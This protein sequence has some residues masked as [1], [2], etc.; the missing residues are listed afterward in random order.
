MMRPPVPKNRDRVLV[1][2]MDLHRQSFA[3]LARYANDAKIIAAFVRLS[4]LIQ[5]TMNA[6]RSAEKES[7]EA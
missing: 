6:L 7:D 5:E 1:A 4:A 3:E 2:L